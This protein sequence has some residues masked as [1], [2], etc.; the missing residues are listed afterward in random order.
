MLVSCDYAASYTAKYPVL[1]IPGFV[2]TG[3]EVWEG[4]KCAQRYFRCAA[5][6]LTVGVQ[7]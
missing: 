5:S 3:L 7:T 2:T 1:M 4:E 6:Q